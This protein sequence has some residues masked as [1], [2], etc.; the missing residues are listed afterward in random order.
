MRETFLD[1]SKKKFEAP[2]E[3]FVSIRQC[4]TRYFPDG[5]KL[6]ASVFVALR[7]LML[8]VKSKRVTAGNDSFQQT[9]INTKAISEFTQRPWLAKVDDVRTLHVSNN[10]DG[11]GKNN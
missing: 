2:G 3:C 1:I 4:A 11:W 5:T 7:N 10:K 6:F 8:Y 9:W